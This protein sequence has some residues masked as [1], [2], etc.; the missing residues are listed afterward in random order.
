MLSP[1]S[2]TTQIETTNTHTRAITVA[3]LVAI[4][5]ELY[6]CLAKAAFWTLSIVIFM[7]LCTFCAG[8]SRFAIPPNDHFLSSTPV[9]ISVCLMPIIRVHEKHFNVP[10]GAQLLAWLRPSF[11]PP[12]AYH[13]D[14]FTCLPILYKY[15]LC[16]Y[17][18]TRLFPHP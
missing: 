4:P 15:N 3:G 5:L 9:L 14:P 6:H 13:T 16:T 18:P 8:G 2:R 1:T 17:I 7:P 12:T 11:D 10:F